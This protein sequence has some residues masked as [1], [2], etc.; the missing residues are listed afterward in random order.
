MT[1]REAATLD[2]F[3]LAVRS[4]SG[5]ALDP[6]LLIG[7]SDNLSCYY[8]PIDWK[9]RN[10]K[11]M[12][13][14]ITPG[15]TQAENALAAAKAQLTT[16]A[17]LVDALAAANRTA[18]FSGS[19][20]P[21]LIALMD[22]IGLNRWLGVSSCSALFTSHPE[23]LQSASVLPYPVYCDGKN[24]NGSPDPTRTP[25]LTNLIEE[26][27]LPFLQGS[28]DAILVPLGP[29]PTRVLTWL[30]SR[31][32]VDPGRVLNGLPHPSGA[33]AERIAYF[34]G[35][36]ARSALSVKTNAEKLDR[37]RDRLVSLVKRLQ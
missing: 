21:N 32:L 19:M 29:V 22:H 2:R 8:A 5:N 37:D 26:H 6:R 31:Q 17:S 35:R 10:A 3:L 9:N 12:L 23:L 25:F 16:G 27:L 30:V 28:P 34:L 7:A 36:K 4:Y 33:N 24:Y 18:A 1:T 15:L 11:V 13:V 20:R 14:G